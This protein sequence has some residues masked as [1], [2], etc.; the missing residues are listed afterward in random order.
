MRS[1]P[2]QYSGF[3]KNSNLGFDL[4]LVERGYLQFKQYFRGKSCLELGPATGY[5][6]KKLVADFQ[7]VT[8]VEGSRSLIEQ[9]PDYPNIVKHNTLFEEYETNDYYDTIILNHVLEHIQKP[10]VLL[11][12]IKKWM[13]SNSILIVGVPNSR[14][15][16]RLA[17]VK[18][19]LLKKENELNKRDKELGH[20]RVYDFQ[21]LRKHV[22]YAGYR[23]I[24]EG[25]V[26]LKFLSNKQIEEY[27]SKDIINAYFELGDLFK[28]NC[29]EIYVI[30]K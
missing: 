21:L 17:A 6:T 20:Y 16:H 13:N 15:F 26:F 25:G 23:I 29:A 18:M 30:A 10:I 4:E 28:D 5:M 8:V 7:K 22:T 19:G 24:N 12:R 3:Y 9:I 11:K 1:N 27:L 14:S 2:E